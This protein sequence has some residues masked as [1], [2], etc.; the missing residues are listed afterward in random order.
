[1]NVSAVARG[2]RNDIAL[3]SPQGRCCGKRR[4]NNIW[5]ERLRNRTAVRLNIAA[6]MAVASLA[7]ALAAQAEPPKRNGGATRQNV[8]TRNVTP[9]ARNVTRPPTIN[10]QQRVIT[11]NNRGPEFRR[12]PEIG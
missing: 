8:P 3:T 1:M 7:F 9:P 4:I 11:P 2:A 12:G 10:Q 5:G 6:L